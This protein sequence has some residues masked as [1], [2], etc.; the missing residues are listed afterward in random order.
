MGGMCGSHIITQCV[1]GHPAAL[2]DQALQQ[3]EEQH[4]CVVGH[5]SHEHPRHGADQCGQ[6]E[7]QLATKPAA[8]EKPAVGTRDPETSK[9]GGGQRGRRQ[10]PQEADPSS[11]LC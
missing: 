1:A 6:Q 8:T 11:V 9:Q 7:T 3:T 5:H 2:A 10:S 4:G